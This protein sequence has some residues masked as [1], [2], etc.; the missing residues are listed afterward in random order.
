MSEFKERVNE[1]VS[2]M[3]Q[4]EDGKW[5]LPE[6]IAKDVDEP[7]MFAITAER[8]Y[9]DTQGAFTKSRQELK[10]QEAIAAGLQEKLLQSN[11]EL[12]KEQKFEL[13]ELKKTNPEAWR[14]KL[15]EIEETNKNKLETELNDIRKASANK[16]E[17]EVRKEQ[18]AAWSESTGIA[19][20][21]EIVANDLPPRFV[22]ELEAGKITFEEF[23]DKA[24]N[25][26]KTEKV[27]AGSTDNTDD[28]ELNLGN[29]AGGQEPSKRA[30]EGDFVE[31]YEKNTIF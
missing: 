20:T 26:L 24:G 23:L 25:F 11:V 18:M 7:T 21:D 14:A 3:E 6:D 4:G 17:L 10:K 8:R 9:R 22:K 31:T 19:L 12:T 16:G 13:N 28:N 27:I 29:V 30:Q 15:N 1:L 5:K 2:K